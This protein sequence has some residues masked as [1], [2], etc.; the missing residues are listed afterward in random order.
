MR[1]RTRRREEPVGE[2]PPR[3]RAPQ[4]AFAGRTREAGA[5]AIGTVGMGAV[6][7]ARLVMLV[8]VLIAI[9]IGLA[10]ILVDVKANPANGVVKG[11]HEGANFFAGE[12]TGLISFAGNHPKRAITVNWGIALIVYLVLGALI[13]GFIARIGRGGLAFDRAAPSH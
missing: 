6:L 4:R 7:I 5:A 2:G 13:A 1:W 11:V 12:F 10:I 9:L 8:A 3:E